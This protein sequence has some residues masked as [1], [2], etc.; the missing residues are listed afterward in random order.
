M[1]P[2]PNLSA[3]AEENSASKCNGTSHRDLIGHD[4]E[5]GL[6]QRKT[7]IFARASHRF[8][9]KNAMEI[10][11]REQKTFD[12]HFWSATGVYLAS[13]CF[14][15]CIGSKT[16]VGRCQITLQFMGTSLAVPTAIV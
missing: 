11:M 16:V 3:D 15:G 5:I 13:S 9:R 12:Y 2:K 6:I 1:K 14:F 8:A 10:N 7:S 4:G